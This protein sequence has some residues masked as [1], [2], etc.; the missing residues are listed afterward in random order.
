M[1]ATEWE[2]VCDWCRGELGSLPSRRLFVGGHISAVVGVE[3][4]DGRTVVVKLRVPDERVPAA[5]AV[6]RRLFDQGF[7]CPEPIAGPSPLGGL[8]ASAEAW[9]PAGRLVGEPPADECAKTLSILVDLAG[10]AVDF[11]ELAAPLPWV[12]WDHGGP[13][14]WPMPDDLGCDLND[15]PGPSWLEDAAKSVRSR[16][17]VDPRP[18]VIGHCD[19]EA[20]N[21]GWREGHVAVVYDWDGLALRSEPAVAGAAATVFPCR[22]GGPVA[23]T[24]AQTEDFLGA[25]RKDRSWWDDDATEVAYAAGLWV[26]LYNARKEYAGGGSGYVGHL[27]SELRQRLHLAGA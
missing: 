22:A 23:A 9:A 19:W 1:E 7:P 11:A 18:P 6:Q 3:L 13:G 10:E 14:T 5:I 24:L 2:G 21:L 15:P 20:N 25:Y 16:L 26:L 8:L 17:A 12:A 4:E 27:D